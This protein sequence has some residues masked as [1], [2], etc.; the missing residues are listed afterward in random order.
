M[1]SNPALQ[2]LAYWNYLQMAATAVA[3]KSA[4]A[5]ATGPS[6]PTSASQNQSQTISQPSI[7][8]AF[9]PTSAFNEIMTAGMKFQPEAS[10]RDQP[11]PTAL[12][13]NASSSSVP[14][15][16]SSMAKLNGAL[17]QIVATARGGPHLAGAGKHDCTTIVH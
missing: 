17:S 4:D 12:F 10:N 15:G 11:L 9:R 1:Y 5:E 8:N 13:S 3:S 7:L 16:S 2:Q 14:T 6:H